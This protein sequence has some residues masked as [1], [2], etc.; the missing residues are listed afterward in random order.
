MPPPRLARQ[1]NAAIGWGTPPSPSAPYPPL[2]LCPSST[3]GDMIRARRSSGYDMTVASAIFLLLVFFPS[4]CFF[5]VQVFSGFCFLCVMIRM[6]PLNT[7]DVFFCFLFLLVNMWGDIRRLIN[8]PQN[9]IYPI[10]FATISWSL[11]NAPFPKKQNNRVWWMV[12]GFLIRG[13]LRMFSTRGVG[14]ALVSVK[15]IYTLPLFVFLE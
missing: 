2:P 11:R 10:C 15:K 6:W 14:G 7:C 4:F 9:K 8:V 5:P 3:A 12:Q 1:K 13:N